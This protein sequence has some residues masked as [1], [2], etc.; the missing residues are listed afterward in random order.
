MSHL[1]PYSEYKGSGT[2]L[3]GKVP[4]HWAVTRMR[5][6][7]EIKK[8]Q[9]GESWDQHLLLSLTLQGVIPRDLENR[10]GK[11]PAD[12]TTYQ[13]V[14]R[15]DLIFCLFDVEETPRTI[16]WVPEPGMLTGAYT[17]AS[18]RAGFDAKYV[19]YHYL[20]FDQRKAYR[21]FYAGLR[22]T[23][24]SQD[25]SNIPLAHPPLSEQRAIVRYLDRETAEIDGFI[26]DQEELIGLLNERRAATVTKAVSHGLSMNAQMKESG[27][28]VVP[29]FPM[30]WVREKL[31]RLGLVMESG[32]SVNGYGDPEDLLGVR[33]LKTGCASK[34]YFDPSE[35]KKVVEEDLLRVSCPVNSG[36][37]IVNRANTPEL[38]G[39]C[40]LADEDY[41][42]LYLSDKLWQLN[43]SR[44]KNRFM[45]WW[46]K[47]PA[48]RAQIRFHAVGAS[49]TM[50]NLSFADFRRF[51]IALPPISEQ[52]E[53]ADY[54]DLETAEI[55]AAITDAKRA[56]ELSKERRAALISAAVTGKIDL[57]NNAA[58]ELGAA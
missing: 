57:R 53:I 41:P 26:A 54:L 28:E 42:N 52:V 38:V 31:S 16:G 32:T 44:A 10:M 24:R 22:N 15:D 9:V 35:N 1:K 13:A 50:Q 23:I 4:V 27:S 47:T 58:V 3:I 43:F 37:L 19:A 51:A 34:G 7:V 48:Y 55:D 12:F 6:A 5:S 40:A 46:M 39:S 8:N 17:A 21:R 29:D 45:Y 18:V 36:S 14:E 33:V 11:M 56:I 2:D 30:H 25:F 20:S 49:A